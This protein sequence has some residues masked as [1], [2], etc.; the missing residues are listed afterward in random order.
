[1][2]FESSVTSHLQYNATYSASDFAG[3]ARDGNVCA[4]FPNTFVGGSTTNLDARGEERLA[5]R[6]RIAQEL[7]DTLLQGFL[8]V[9]MQL[10]AAVDHLPAD[11]PEKPHFSDVLK[12]LDR[13]LEQGRCAVQGLRSPTER[14]EPLS[15][16]FAGVP[17]DL[18]LPS[19]VGFRVVV[20][21]K[22]RDLRA[23]LHEEVYRIGR[24]AIVNAYR[25]SR[26]RVIETEVE[27]RPTDLRIAVRDDGCGIDPQD[28]QWG[29]SGHWGLRGMRER[30][31]RIGARL[32]L[33]S[34]VELG[35]EVELCVP[36]RA[37]FEQSES[38]A[39]GCPLN[40]NTFARVGRQ[41]GKEGVA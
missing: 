35:T 38:G 29:R 32:R 37:A 10:Q 31:E 15:E 2:G 18:G 17:D 21:G 3:M 27:Y 26:A 24:E 36:G 25:H 39:S 23:G 22:E 1:M 34:R 14:N 8:A 16:A 11:F 20:H 7:H 13:V 12:M 19:A 30:A 6:T 9:S 5:E 40:W 4:L 41:Y 33:W 28:L